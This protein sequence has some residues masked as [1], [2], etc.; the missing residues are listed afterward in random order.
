[1]GRLP[2]LTF[3]ALLTAAMAASAAAQP[4][5]N[6]PPAQPGGQL[7]PPGP[8]AP[9]GQPG[10][11]PLPP[12]AVIYTMEQIAIQQMTP[13]LQQALQPLNTLQQVEDALKVRGVPFMWRRAEVNSAGLPPDFARQL[14]ALPPHEVFVAPQGRGGAVMG[15]IVQQRPAPAGGAA[16]PP[17][18]PTPAKKR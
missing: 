7:F 15:T 5:P 2:K 9:A 3:A 10:V 17:P 11:M 1:M 16:A 14:A 18:A 6:T 8:S 4:T 12:P 13:E